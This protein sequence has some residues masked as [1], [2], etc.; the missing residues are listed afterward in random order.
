M[1]GQITAMETGYGEFLTKFPEQ[2]IQLAMMYDENVDILEAE[3]VAIRVVL[4]ENTMLYGEIGYA[5]QEWKM[6]SPENREK[7]TEFL[8]QEYRKAESNA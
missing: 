4:Y 2:A 6:P 8:E 1:M 7:M 3:N 5:G